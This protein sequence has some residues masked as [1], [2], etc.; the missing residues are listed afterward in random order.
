MAAN[1]R[2]QNEA[3]AARVA[4]LEEKIAAMAG[5]DGIKSAKPK[6]K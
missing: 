6:K 1:A 3:L 5:E 2:A 4:A